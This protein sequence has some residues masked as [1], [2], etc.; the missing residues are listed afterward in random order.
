M[1]TLRTALRC[2]FFALV[3]TA[4]LSAY[5][6]NYDVRVFFDT[7]ANRATGCTIPTANGPVA[8]VEQVLT[9]SVTVNGGIGTVT[10]VTRQQCVNGLFFGDPVPVNGG[11]NV[12]V[13]STGNLFIETHVGANV[14]TMTNI[15]TMRL[16]FTVTS[17]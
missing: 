17:G 14:M 2:I 13:S 7:D 3:F 12:G 9:T 11:W 5:A 15:P 8:G 6:A 4:P 10:G 1:S 16:A